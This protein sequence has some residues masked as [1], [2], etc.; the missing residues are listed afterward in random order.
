M[1]GL[2]RGFAFV[3]ALFITKLE[4]RGDEFVRP[5]SS[6]IKI[7]GLAGAPTR[8]WILN[9]ISFEVVH[10]MSRVLM[11]LPD[12]LATALAINKENLPDPD[13]GGFLIDLVLQL[14]EHYIK[15]AEERERRY[16]DKPLFEGFL[17]IFIS[18]NEPYLL[19]LV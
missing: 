13:D 16:E 12:K 2:L 14:L 7:P 6:L 8:I 4:H 10:G 11:L 17:F 18:G 19:P 9:L 3:T 5:K 1:T 15:I